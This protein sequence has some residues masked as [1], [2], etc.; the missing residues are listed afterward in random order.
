M[1]IWS[2]MLGE[3]IRIIFIFSSGFKQSQM[4]YILLFISE[5]QYTIYMDPNSLNAFL[6]R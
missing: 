4:I 6:I 1:L 3:A 2:V 5:I